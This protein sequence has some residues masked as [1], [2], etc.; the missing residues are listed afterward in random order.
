[1]IDDLAGQLADQLADQHERLGRAVTAII[2]EYAGTLDTRKV[3]SPATPKELE[4]IFDEPFPE[5]G[6]TTEEILATV[7]PRCART[8]DAGSE[9]ALLRPV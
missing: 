3:T 4:K 2:T 1:M 7:Y 9:P 6:I 5:H 8:C